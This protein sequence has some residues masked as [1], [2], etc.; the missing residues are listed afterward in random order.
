MYNLTIPSIHPSYDQ[1]R[2]RFIYSTANNDYDLD[3]A[4]VGSDLTYKECNDN[5]YE[6]Q[7]LIIITRNVQI[8]VCYKVV[9]GDQALNVYE[10][11]IE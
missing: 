7:F 9:I 10:P 11:I 2:W 8:D 5:V 1:G 3:T 6:Y 4:S